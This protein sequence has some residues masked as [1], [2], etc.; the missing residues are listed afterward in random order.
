ML[1]TISILEHS[2]SDSLD[3][4]LGAEE[5]QIRLG[6]QCPAGVHHKRSHISFFLTLCIRYRDYRRSVEV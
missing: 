6:T 5:N 2:E 1:L 3:G 4:V